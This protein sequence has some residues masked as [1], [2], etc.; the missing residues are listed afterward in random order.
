MVAIRVDGTM[1][2]MASGTVE[3]MVN[4]MEDNREGGTAATSRPGTS[5]LLQ[6]HSLPECMLDSALTTHTATRWISYLIIV[7]SRAKLDSN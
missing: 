2:T 6:P 3:T 7:T 5:S 4:G 1:E